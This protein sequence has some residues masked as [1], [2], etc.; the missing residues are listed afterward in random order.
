MARLARAVTVG[1]AHHITQRGNHRQ[2][3]FHHDDDRRLYLASLRET[4]PRYGATI[5]ATVV[6]QPGNSVSTGR[7]PA[8]HQIS[9]PAP[10]SENNRSY[11]E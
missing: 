4:A 8:G 1:I 7:T 9:L 10:L 6:R 3:V 5:S 11:L 2:T